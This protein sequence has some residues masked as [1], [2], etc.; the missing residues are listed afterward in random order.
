M[1]AALIKN[2]NRAVPLLV[3]WSLVLFFNVYA[4]IRN[5]YGKKISTLVQPGTDFFITHV[6]LLKW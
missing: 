3:A 5:R 2:F 4:L 6:V 1:I